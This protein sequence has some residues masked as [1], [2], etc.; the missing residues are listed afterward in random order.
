VRRAALAALVMN[1][2]IV[3][4]GGAVR[5]TASGLGCPTW[6]RC[7]DASL[8]ATRAMGVHGAI[9]F[10]NRMLTY[11]LA[12]A[13]GAAIVTTMRELPR[14]P[15]L[16]RLAWSLFVGIVAQALLGGLTVMTGLNPVTVMAHF[17]LSMVL[18][19]VAV[20]LYELTVDARV[21]VVRRELRLAC[22]FVVGVAAVT[23]FLG[24]VV[25]GSGPHSGD[26]NAT[27]RL[28][29]DPRSVTQLHADFVFLLVGLALGL[30]LALRAAGAAR[31]A[32][33]VAVLVV[34]LLGQG[35]VGFVQYATN[36]PV[37]LVAVHVLGACLVW[38]AA[39]RVLLAV[40]TSPAPPSTPER[41]STTLST[42]PRQ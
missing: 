35:T 21:D 20:V 32:A 3:V 36:V 7:T 25:T 2:V 10:G 40:P 33:R 29:F 24:T 37:A 39:L 5:L 41:T 26:R 42:P 4:T 22:W 23:L 12:L 17:L 8:V 13:V 27:H 15:L 30:L 6:P 11:V 16:V 38:I 19:A 1:T 34:V 28:P 14:R 9:E 31:A 18:I